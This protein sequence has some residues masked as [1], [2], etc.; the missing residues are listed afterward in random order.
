MSNGNP[1]YVHPGGDMTQGMAGL[2]QAIQD[3]G[4]RRDEKEGRVRAE[5]RF[6]EAKSAAMTA[7]QSGDSD[8]IAEMAIEYP[9]MQQ[10]AQMLFGITN[11]NTKELTI[12]A[13]Q[14]ALLDTD[15]AEDIMKTLVNDV[16]DAG[17]RPDKILS[18]FGA[19][20]KDKQAGLKQME[21][22]LAVSAPEFYQSLQDRKAE[23][24]SQQ[25]LD[26]E[27]QKLDKV[28]YKM[29][30]GA[31]AGYSFD[32][33]TGTFSIDPKIKADLAK[34]ASRK[35]AKTGM[36]TSK[37]IA[38]VNDKV[39]ALTKDTSA[40]V[41]SAKSLQA[42][43]ANSSAASKLAAVFQFMKSLDPTSVVRETEQGQ[44]YAASGAA[45]Q[46]AGKLNS[47]IG[48]GQL[49]EA[50]FQDIVNTSIVLAD[51]AIDVSNDEVSSYLSVLQDKVP[52]EDLK[53][54]QARVPERMGGARTDTVTPANV[55]LTN[56]QGWTLQE[57]ASGNRAYVGPG[58]EIEEI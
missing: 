16:S 31:M 52:P 51:S 55:P 21:N 45:A 42:L 29:G 17:G 22:G 46:I 5:N 3:Y 12:Q 9:E 43:K 39:T 6:K 4:E 47:L 26:M 38:G 2:G 18:D 35:A 7:F 10:T 58:G 56:P 49:T 11:E 1:F 40:I 27:Q 34:D 8:Q 33:S 20:L 41:K 19:L 14:D 36:L 48:E 28:T 24:M 37:D 30:S 54:L 44:V 57:D 53:K 32:D 25:K 23:N 13:Y 15:N 50:G